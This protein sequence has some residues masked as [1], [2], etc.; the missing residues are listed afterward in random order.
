MP[1]DNVLKHGKIPAPHESA[2]KVLRTRLLL[3]LAILLPIMLQMAILYKEAFSAPFQD[4]Y[5]AILEFGLTY[6]QM[7]GLAPKAL[8][9]A[10]EQ[11]NE[12]KLVFE[13]IVVATELSLWHRLDFRWLI[14]LGDAFPLLIGCVLWWFCRSP[15][16]RGLASWYRFLP[17]SLIFFALT[18]WETLDWAMASLQNLPVVFFS[19]LSLYLIGPVARSGTAMRFV[20]ACI[21]AALAASSSANGFLVLPVGLLALI[22]RRAYV[23][24]A[25]WCLCFVLPLAAY[26][27]RYKSYPHTVHRLW[28]L[29]RPLDFVSFLGGVLHFRWI[30]TALGMLI[31]I[32][33]GLAARA[34]YDRVQPV[35]YLWGAW[36]IAT[37]MLVGWV[38]GSAGFISQP[39]R[40]SIYSEVM[41]VLCFQFLYR[42]LPERFSFF[43]R[44][45]TYVLLVAI[46]A[47]VCFTA[48]AVAFHKLQYRQRMVNKG[49]ELYSENPAMNSPMID[50]AV[51]RMAPSE[52]DYERAILTQ[53]IQSGLLTIPHAENA[54]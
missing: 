19:L 42:T 1:S 24:S 46:S 40:Y 45:S 4:D 36:I 25:V 43:R 54:R 53:S 22:P 28:F 8:F 12:Y 2:Q 38:R 5:H 52:K 7:H 18:Y 3:S 9:I 16:D 47:L 26:L 11:H 48:D 23:K 44:K 20:F 50:P 37:A 30:A 34:R 27:Y 10:S 13:H 32:I 29:T 49:F 17:V 31:L 39:S 35:A 14:A 41:I 15:D 51:E 33:V 21:A 6:N